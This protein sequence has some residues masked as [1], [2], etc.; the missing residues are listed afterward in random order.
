MGFLRPCLAAG[1]GEIVSG[2]YCDAH[3]HKAKST[4]PRK[5][6]YPVTYDS[7]WVRLRAIHK[8]AYPMCRTCEA[9]GR[10]RAVQ[11]VD[12]IVSFRGSVTLLRAPWNL[13]SLCRSCHHRKTNQDTEWAD[14]THPLP[15]KLP[16]AMTAVCGPPGSGK[17]MWA[18]A[19]FERV[20]DLDDIRREMGLGRMAVSLD[21]LKAMLARRNVRLQAGLS[22]VALVVSAPR[23]VDRWFWS[24]VWGADVVWMDAPLEVCRRRVR[25]RADD[26]S[27]RGWD[28]FMARYEAP[29]ELE[30]I[31]F[32]AGC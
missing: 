27:V 15:T 17:T 24:E 23:A 32:V 22:P 10:T 28:R 16:E 19:N 25:A 11:E 14:Y 31:R 13:Q 26:E 29:T 3:A 2:T 4:M 20:I 1:C 18:K 7:R 21:A 8:Q 30:P 5:E 6:R 9:E 12:H